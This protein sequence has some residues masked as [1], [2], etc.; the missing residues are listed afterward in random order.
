MP[1]YMCDADHARIV[2]AVSQDFEDCRCQYEPMMRMH[3]DMTEFEASL[4]LAYMSVE[5]MVSEIVTSRDDTKAKTSTASLPEGKRMDIIFARHPDEHDMRGIQSHMAKSKFKK[6]AHGE[7]ARNLQHTGCGPKCMVCDMASGA[8]RT[9]FKIVDKYMETRS[10]Y[11]LSMDMQVL[12]HRS[13]AGNRYY[14]TVRD[15]ASKYIVGF[16]LAKKNDILHVFKA[17]LI[18]L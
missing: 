16:K 6:M 7:F 3:A 1:A 5:A 15:M 10:G 4:V 13:K 18:S 2:Q 9:I 12:S 14:I 11:M 17:W 8:M